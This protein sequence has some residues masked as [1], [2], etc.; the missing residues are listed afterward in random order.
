MA[1]RSIQFDDNGSLLMA[2]GTGAS[3]VKGAVWGT[4]G[5][6]ITTAATT[7]ITSAAAV[8]TYVTDIAVTN[9]SDTVGTLVTIQDDTPT[10]IYQGYAGTTGGGFHVTL[11]TPRATAVAKMVQA[12]CS[13][14]AASV[15][16]SVGGFRAA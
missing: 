6:I 11:T 3:I 8:K 7:I 13:T 15:Y 12:V 1:D 2:A 10:T 5:A 16:V 9:L 14:T 4:T